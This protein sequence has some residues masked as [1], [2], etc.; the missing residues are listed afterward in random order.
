MGRN[1]L[2]P[3]GLHPMPGAG[4]SECTALEMLFPGH[5]GQLMGRSKRRVRPGAE[6]LQDGSYNDVLACS[7]AARSLARR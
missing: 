2:S 1:E 4:V 6:P 7:D 3:P 5:L